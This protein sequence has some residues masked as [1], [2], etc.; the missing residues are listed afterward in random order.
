M[1]D[2]YPWFVTFDRSLAVDSTG[3]CL[4]EL[5]RL[6]ENEE[7]GQVFEELSCALYGPVLWDEQIVFA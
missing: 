2:D 7:L 1:Y 5:S 4:V 6:V 3:G